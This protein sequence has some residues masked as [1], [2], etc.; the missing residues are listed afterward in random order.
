MLEIK[1]KQLLSFLTFLCLESLLQNSYIY[2]FFA[3]FAKN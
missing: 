2:I 3:K 1:F